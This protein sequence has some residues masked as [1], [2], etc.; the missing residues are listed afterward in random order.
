MNR[1]V[2]KPTYGNGEYYY[3]D[4]FS[5]SLKIMQEKSTSLLRPS[6]NKTDLEIPVDY[7]QLFKQQSDLDII[8]YYICSLIINKNSY[9]NFLV[10]LKKNTCHKM[11]L[12]MKSFLN[13]HLLSPNCKFLKFFFHISYSLI[14]LYHCR[15]DPSTLGFSELWE[16]SPEVLSTKD[17]QITKCEP[18]GNLIYEETSPANIFYE[19]AKQIPSQPLQFDVRY[20]CRMLNLSFTNCISIRILWKWT[21]HP[22]YLLY[23]LTIFPPKLAFH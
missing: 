2:S 4:P 22:Y 11:P 23:Q 8:Q 17:L 12:T 16:F 14:Q 7:Q 21:H 13:S 20:L 9:R 18:F 10:G 15:D 5:S 19:R 6:W 3:E 1:L